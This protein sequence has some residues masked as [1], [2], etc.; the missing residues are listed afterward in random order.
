MNIKY[1]CPCCGN[2]SLELSPGQFE[3]CDICDWEDDPIQRNEPDYSGGA[4]KISLNEAKEKFKK[5]GKI[6]GKR[7]V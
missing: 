1:K 2:Y 5:H 4:N 6:I 7:R 3:I